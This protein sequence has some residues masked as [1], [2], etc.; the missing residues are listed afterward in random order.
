M[1][2]IFCLSLAAKSLACY[3][4][5]RNSKVLVLP[6][7]RRLK[8]YRN[9]IKPK[10]GFQE[11]V[12]EELK[13]QTNSYFDVQSYVVLLFDEIKIMANL[14]LDKVTRELIG[15]TDLGDL[16]LSYGALM[17]VDEIATH[18]LA[19]LVR[20]ICTQLKLCL[21][22]FASTGVTATQPMPLFWEAVCML[23]T[24]R[25]LWVIGVTS[26]GASPN[27]RFYQLHKPIDGDA[28]HDVCYRTV[29]LYAP[30]RFVYFFADAPLLTIVSRAL[31]MTY[32]VCARS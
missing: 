8:D 28:A 18:A 30:H 25:N 16:E 27:R 11:E 1:I 2:I 10:R 4:E 13:T 9:F 24:T 19:F 21:A 6:S 3:E 5:L 31:I 20:G 15:F 14:V 12:A 17:K 22:H 32:C 23:E 7:Q 26:D 29:N